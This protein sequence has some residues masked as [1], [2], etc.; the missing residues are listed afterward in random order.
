MLV[1]PNV[2]IFLSNVNVGNLCPTFCEIRVSTVETQNFELLFLGFYCKN[3][4]SRT[5]EPFDIKYPIK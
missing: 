3:Q 4:K 1:K 2:F 5:I